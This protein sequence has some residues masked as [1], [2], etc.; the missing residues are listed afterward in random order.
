MQDKMKIY[1]EIGAFLTAFYF[2]LIL[3][4]PRQVAILCDFEQNWLTGVMLVV[5]GVLIFFLYPLIMLA[6]FIE[7]WIWFHTRKEG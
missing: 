2:L 1:I 4:F 5:I 7:F 6:L 3:F